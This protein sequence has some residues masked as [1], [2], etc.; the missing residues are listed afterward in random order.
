MQSWVGAVGPMTIVMMVCE[1]P[2]TRV[3][4]P[5]RAPPELP[6][7]PPPHP[8]PTQASVTWPLS[9]QTARFQTLASTHSWVWRCARCWSVSTTWCCPCGKSGSSQSASCRRFPRRLA[10]LMVGMEGVSPQQHCP[11]RALGLRAGQGLSIWPVPESPPWVP[12]GP[13]P[14][15]LATR[16][17]HVC[18]YVC[19]CGRGP[20]GIVPGICSSSQS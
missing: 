15:A 16:S 1:D 4:Y 13:H 9:T 14:P 19:V 12:S 8:L 18:M 20:Y 2:V 6:T 10:Q 17:Q 7:E 11:L 5:P 3:Q